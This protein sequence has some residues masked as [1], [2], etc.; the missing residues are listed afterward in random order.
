MC[1]YILNCLTHKKILPMGYLSSDSPVAKLTKHVNDGLDANK[2]RFCVFLDL[3][4]AFYMV[5]KD[6]LLSQLITYAIR[7]L[8]H[9]L[10]RSY[11]ETRQQYVKINSTNSSTFPRGIVV[12]HSS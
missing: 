10:L 3:R 2:F 9:Q 4:K 12:P 1:E 7:D 11:L 8:T 6:I 5:N